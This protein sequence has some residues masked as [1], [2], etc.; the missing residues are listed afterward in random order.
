MKAPSGFGDLDGDVVIVVL[1]A[2]AHHAPPPPVG[3]ARD[4]L[5]LGRVER[6]GAA[7]DRD[8]AAGREARAGSAVV[9][10]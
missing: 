7:G 5:Q 1:R 8:G 3:L 4:G 10:A 9:T 6:L 2:G